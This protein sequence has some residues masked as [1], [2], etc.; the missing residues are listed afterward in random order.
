[1]SGYAY[2]HVIK[3]K[4][5]GA[6]MSY[7]MGTCPECGAKSKDMIK[8]ERHGFITFFI[9][10]SIVLGGL[11]IISGIISLFSSFVL[12]LHNI[13]FGLLVAIAGISTLLSLVG[14]AGYFMLL[15]WRLLGLYLILGQGLVQILIGSIIVGYLSDPLM[16]IISFMVS[17]VGLLIGFIILDVILSIKKNEVPYIEAMTLKQEWGKE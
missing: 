8:L 3:C 17:T 2:D 12:F 7:Y 13:S 11:G 6:N 9:G 1:M 10:L 15:K 14:I 5:C 4:K 16:G